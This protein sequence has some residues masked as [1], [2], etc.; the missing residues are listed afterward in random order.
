MN[1]ATEIKTVVLLLMLSSS[2][3]GNSVEN[4]GSEEFA[5]W[6]KVVTKDLFQSIVGLGEFSAIPEDEKIIYVFIYRPPAGDPDYIL[7]AAVEVGSAGTL[8]DR[9]EHKRS[10]VTTPSSER[11]G[12]FPSVGARAQMTAPFFGPGGSSFGLLSTTHDERFDLNVNVMQSGA[13]GNVATFDVL[14]I[15]A[16]LHQAYDSLGS[17]TEKE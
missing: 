1:T 4:F 16:R 15:S 8:L 11:A 6:N 9:A 12:R 7:S 14:N 13:E 2:T 3:L 5:L 10:M 17:M